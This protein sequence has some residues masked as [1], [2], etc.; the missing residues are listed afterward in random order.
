MFDNSIM[1]Y[2]VSDVPELT[3]AVLETYYEELEQY[4]ET[5]EQLADV[6]GNPYS[7]TYTI[8]EF[9]PDEEVEVIKILLPQKREEYDDFDFYYIVKTHTYE[10]IYSSSIGNVSPGEEFLRWNKT[11]S[12]LRNESIW[13]HKKAKTLTYSKPGGFYYQGQRLLVNTGK[14]IAASIK[15]TIGIEVNFFNQDEETRI[16]I[17]NLTDFFLSGNLIEIVVASS[18]SITPFNLEIT[19]YGKRKWSAL[20]PGE[21]ISEDILIH[22]NNLAIKDR[23]KPPGMSS[24]PDNFWNSK[25]YPLKFKR[26]LTS[27]N[28]AKWV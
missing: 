26:D 5:G 8:L 7:R 3:S 4:W 2:S 24:L 15:S 18:N 12:K 10:T 11:K 28:E 6:N 20:L 9:I 14:Y 22:P 1:D 23:L 17:K 13:T 25:E 21:Q 19:F 16:P 27:G